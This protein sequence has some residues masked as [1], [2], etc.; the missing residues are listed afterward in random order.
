[1]V[2]SLLSFLGRPIFR[3]YLKLPGSNQKFIICRY[4]DM[5]SASFR[6]QKEISVSIRITECPPK[7]KNAGKKLLCC[8]TLTSY[9][10]SYNPYKWPYR[11]ITGVIS[12]CISGVISP[13]L[14]EMA[15]LCVVLCISRGINGSWIFTH[16]D[17]QHETWSWSLPRR[18]DGWWV[19][20]HPRGS[21]LAAHQEASTD[22]CSARAEVL[23]R[24][25]ERPQRSGCDS[26]QRRLGP[27]ASHLELVAS[28]SAWSIIWKIRTYVRHI[29]NQ[30]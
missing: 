6:W 15:E 8:K 4:T 17:W 3:S 7:R 25:M 12:P 26:G 20:V 1:M 19:G 14:S 29:W 21:S 5:L 22:C 27:D 16:G 23:S 30:T 18:R 9:T 10:W 28:A 24:I 11:F 13:Y 2:G